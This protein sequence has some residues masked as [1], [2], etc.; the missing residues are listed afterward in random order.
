M[1]AVPLSCYIVAC[2]EADRI[3]RALASVKGLAGEIVVV[4]SGSS[5]GTEQIAKDL[6][7]RVLHRKWDGFGNQK[8]FAED[9]CRH[10]WLLNL[11]AD[12]WL[13]PEL[14]REIRALFAQGAPPDPVYHVRVKD[15]LPGES[16]PRRWR[17]GWSKHPLYDRRRT[18]MRPI[19]DHA[20]VGLDKLRV[21]RLRGGLHHQPFRSLAHM[22]EKQIR[23][24][25][26][27]AR[28]PKPLAVCL[29]RLPGEALWTFLLNYIL[30]REFLGG[31]RAYIAAKI[32]SFGRFLRIAQMIEARRNWT[33]PAPPLTAPPPQTKN[34]ALAP[35][36]CTIVAMNEADRIGRAMAS[37]RGLAG[38]ILI[39]DSG[40]SD[41]T[42]QIAKN[43]G[44]RVLH[45][46]WD[47]FGNQK[48]F[49]EEQAGHDWILNLDADEWL[50]PEL[51]EELR[52]LFAAGP[53]PRAAYTL[54]RREIWPGR[55][56]PP[57]FNHPWHV[58]RF[59]DKREA[60]FS[61]KL[62]ADGVEISPARTG[63]LR[64]PFFHAPLR[65]LAGLAAKENAYTDTERAYKKSP[66]TLF[67]RLPAE[68]LFYFVKLYILRRMIFA[69]WQGYI[70]ARIY[71]FSRF[72]RIAKQIEN[73]GAWR[74]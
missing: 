69:G 49:A 4:D 15:C 38:E 25:Q 12:E 63:H 20:S 30:R 14:A 50:S 66:Q 22:V 32:R 53:P 55:T 39:V 43:F 44:A 47:G 73:H 24:G 35:I 11:D 23:Y 57:P 19:H 3:A 2:N 6:G 21:G 58:I 59:Y 5:D 27:A 51:A 10:H 40:S 67:L 16:E 62:L 60:R 34:R 33:A 9:Q 28:H 8:R 41:G 71:S 31:R 65:S 70:L 13:S 48:R 17:R 45:R 64:A 52:G 54:P 29:L 7:A 72:L 56:R 42:G 36:T 61:T 46:D 26:D 74:P 1:T 37:V 18:R 68:S